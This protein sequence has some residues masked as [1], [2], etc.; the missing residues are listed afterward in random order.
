MVPSGGSPV[1]RPCTFCGKLL[2]KSSI[3]KHVQDIHSPPQSVHCTYCTKQFR[4]NNSLQNHMSIYH[5][6]QRQAT[7]QISGST[8]Q[9]QTSK[10]NEFDK[11]LTNS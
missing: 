1:L 5:R 6:E 10:T 4:T 8:H 3:R 9:Q 2:R 7:R 11:L